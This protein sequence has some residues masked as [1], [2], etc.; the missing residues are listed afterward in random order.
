MAARPFRGLYSFL[1]ADGRFL[2]QNIRQP[3]SASF[4]PDSVHFVRHRPVFDRRPRILLLLAQSKA[5]PK[6]RSNVFRPPDLEIFWEVLYPSPSMPDSIRGKGVGSAMVQCCVPKS[7]GTVRLSPTGAHDITVD[8]LVDPN[9]LSAPEDWLIYRR[10]ILFGLEIAKEMGQRGY[11]I[12]E[13]YPLQSTSSKHL[14]DFIRRRGITGQHP[15]SSCRMKPLEEGGVVDQE[16][17]VYGVRGSRIA[18]GSV[19]PTIVA[20]RPQATIVMIAEKCADFIMENWKL[21]DVVEAM[22]KANGD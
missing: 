6:P 3:S 17:K 12:S 8:P 7:I 20:S 10:G 22:A 2:S 11:P 9:Y 15:L 14:D 21:N 4:G 19:F 13:I 5:T 16:L 1:F 18:D